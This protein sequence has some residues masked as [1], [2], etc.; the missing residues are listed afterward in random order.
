MRSFGT[1][2]KAEAVRLGGRQ[3]IADQ[4]QES[5]R[6]GRSVTARPRG[7]VGDNSAAATRP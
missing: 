7:P 1:R 3:R 5:R 4:A 2:T 6:G